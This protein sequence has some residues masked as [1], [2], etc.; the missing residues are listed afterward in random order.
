MLHIFNKPLSHYQKQQLIIAPDDKLLLLSDAC[1]SVNCYIDAFCQN[2][3]YALDVDMKARAISNE[4]IITISDQQWVEL[5]VD[6]E[7]HITW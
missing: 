6:S 3:L 2:A 1:Y 4:T 7:Q 5:I